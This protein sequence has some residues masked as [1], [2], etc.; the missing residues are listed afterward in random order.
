MW[1]LFFAC[2]Q[3]TLC[4]QQVQIAGKSHI[5]CSGTTGSLVPWGFFSKAESSEH[6]DV[7]HISEPA[8]AAPAPCHWLLF[9]PHPLPH[10]GAILV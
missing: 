7:S 10:A 4:P 5:N 8:L 2:I 3:Q 9:P 1:P 6:D